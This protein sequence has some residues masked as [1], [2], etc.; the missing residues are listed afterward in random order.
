MAHDVIAARWAR[1]QSLMVKQ[2]FDALLITEKYNFWYFT[3]NLTRELEK[4][5]RPMIVL[6]PAGGDP[7]VIVYRQAEKSIRKGA[8]VNDFLTYEDVP[9]PIELV[10]EAVS[11]RGLTKARIGAEFGQYERFGMSIGQFETTKEQLP[12]VTFSDAS[13]IFEELRI[14]KMPDEVD[15]IRKA[16]ALSLRAWDK[17]VPRF[18]FGMVNND[19]K[20]VLAAALI[21]E[22]SDFDIAGHVTMGNG[23]HGNEPYRKGQTVWCDF[24][25]T[26]KGYQA[27]LARRAIFGEPDEIQAEYHR[28]ISEIL[29]EEI[30]AIRPGIRAS[31]VATVASN[32]MVKAGYKPLSSKKRVGH[33]VGLCAA[34]AP[35][36][37]LADDTILMPG[38]VLTPEPRFDLP[39]GERMHI[40]EMVVVTETG[41]EVLS[42]GADRL[43][44]VA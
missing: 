35:S 36:L 4:K 12:G 27:D 2:G 43:A 17:A 18:E 21:E 11:M 30:A 8:P 32:A 5:M 10:A 16:C 42:H 1:A 28:Q 13:A 24:G 40:E 14:V 23:I 15:L 26:W 41:C 19:L 39:T 20:R 44:V 6:L 3:G 25:G 37:S 33:G 9:F 34:E 38:M 31:D 22:G 29:H 7:V